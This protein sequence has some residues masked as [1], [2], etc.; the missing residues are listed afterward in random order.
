MTRTI[1]WLMPLAAIVC[2][3][4]AP[5]RSPAPGPSTAP[6]SSAAPT[7]GGMLNGRAWTAATRDAK[8]MY[9]HGI[10][11]GLL[12][13]AGIVTVKSDQERMLT[14]TAQDFRPSDYIDE[15]NTFYQQSGSMRIPI[16]YAWEF[17]NSKFKGASAAQLEAMMQNFRAFV[18]AH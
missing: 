13:G 9:I 4:Q 2:R 16:F 17:I 8:L 3:A 7:T 12:L 5:S 15:I 14:H 18:S 6:S 10:E 1:L 11:E